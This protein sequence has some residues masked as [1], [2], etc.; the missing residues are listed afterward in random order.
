MLLLQAKRIHQLQQITSN[1]RIDANS[2]LP[3][4][5]WSLAKIV[6]WSHQL[7]KNSTSVRLQTSKTAD[8]FS[9]RKCNTCFLL[10]PSKCNKCIQK[11]IIQ[12]IFIAAAFLLNQRKSFDLFSAG[13]IWS[14]SIADSGAFLCTWR[15]SKRSATS[16]SVFWANATLALCF[17]WANAISAFYLP[18]S[19]CNTCILLPLWK[20]NKVEQPSAATG[21]SSKQIGV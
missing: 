10:S 15:I 9:R 6:A 21:C 8:L 4:S 7:R 5:C 14:Q 11:W 20:H 19:N 18:L 1:E 3:N 17:R 16:L 13:R 2:M 12:C